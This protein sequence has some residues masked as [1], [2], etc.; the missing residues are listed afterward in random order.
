MRFTPPPF[1]TIFN[2]MK[3][4]IVL[5]ISLFLLTG[6]FRNDIRTATFQ[7]DQLRTPESAQL[8]AQSLRGLS[9]IKE[10]RPNLDKKNLTIIFNGR[11]IY[12]KNIE[13]AIVD[14]GFSLPNWP[15]TEASKAKLPEEL[16]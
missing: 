16:R 9:G 13:Y 1:R 8:L 12:L 10:F 2:G 3:K 7:I 14:A 11:E 15:A 6:C 4:L 5:A